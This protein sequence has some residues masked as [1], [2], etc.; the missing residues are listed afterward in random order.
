MPRLA[1]VAA[2]LLAAGSGTR[3]GGALPKQFRLLAGRLFQRERE[4]Q[5]SVTQFVAAVPVAVVKWPSSVE[6]LPRV[7]AM[8]FA[9][10]TGALLDD[11]GADLS[12]RG[13]GRPS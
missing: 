12:P 6:A 1:H 2:I 8:A 5:Y 4:C 7:H 3:S 9:G 13:S 11:D 10:R